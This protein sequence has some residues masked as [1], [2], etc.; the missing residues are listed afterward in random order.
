LYHDAR[1]HE[2]Q[3]NTSRKKAMPSHKKGDFVTK[4]GFL[5]SQNGSYCH[6]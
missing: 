5:L 2:G 6:K 3:V 1:I 4:R